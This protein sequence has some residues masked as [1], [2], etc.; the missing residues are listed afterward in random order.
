MG[1]QCAKKTDSKDEVDTTPLNQPVEEKEKILDEHSAIPSVSEK[2][3]KKKKKKKA[4]ET[5]CKIYL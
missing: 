5:E 3:S 4:E 2:K 1:C